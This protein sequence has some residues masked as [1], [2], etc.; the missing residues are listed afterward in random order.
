MRL[1][2]LVLISALALLAACT[3]KPADTESDTGDT[4][5]T[6]TTAS[7]GAEETSAT[8]PTTTTAEPGTASQSTQDATGGTTGDPDPTTAT[9]AT[10]TT[11]NP[12]DEPPE[13]LPGACEVLCNVL[14]EC[15]QGP[16]GPDCI[17]GCIGE[18][19]PGTE[20]AML[21]ADLWLCVADLTCEQLEQ[22]METETEFCL[23]EI[24]AHDSTCGDGGCGMFAGGGSGSCSVGL[25]CE[26]LE[27]EYRCEGDTCTCIENEVPGVTC[28]NPG[29][30]GE[31]EGEPDFGGLESAAQMCCG[32]DW[33]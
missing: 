14:V 5:D 16:P 7:G 24:E 33:S 1:P 20:C 15:G 9:T 6:G 25:S 31:D 27:Q 17:E 11:A 3:P 18:E 4:G 23:A 13:T 28:P 8:A 26:G 2:S 19:E 12:T 32:W 30:C 21:L 10:V 29:L 22:F